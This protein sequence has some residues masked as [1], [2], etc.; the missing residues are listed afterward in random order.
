MPRQPRPRGLTLPAE[1]AA[2]TLVLR[3]IGKAV[4]ENGAMRTGPRMRWL[5]RNCGCDPI[6]NPA[7]AYG[8]PTTRGAAS[9]RMLALAQ[10]RTTEPSPS[11]PSP[12]PMSELTIREAVES[13]IE[14]LFEIRAGTRENAIPRTY[15]ASIG[16]TPESWAAGLASEDERTWVCL[17]GMTPV[18]FCG[19]DAVHGEVVV[20]A[21]LPDYE[22]RGIGKRLLGQAVAWLR[23]RG[24]RRIWL[25]AN[26]DPGVRSHGFYRSQGWRPTGEVQERAGDEIL[27]LEEPP[28]A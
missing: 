19:A 22:R 3:V 10:L 28:N 27:T 1:A 9:F 8:L 17:D 12:V 20:L 18:A 11:A 6:E 21:V 25:A 23:S 13:D 24:C 15:L 5:C 26:P 16:I 2:N 4:A 7:T 14:A